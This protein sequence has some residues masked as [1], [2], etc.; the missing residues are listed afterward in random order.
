MLITPKYCGHIVVVALSALAFCVSVS[1]LIGG[2]DGS[3]SDESASEDPE[4]TTTMRA[5]EDDVF[6]GDESTLVTVEVEERDLESL[7]TIGNGDIGGMAVIDYTCGESRELYCKLEDLGGMCGITIVPGFR[8]DRGRELHQL[9]LGIWRMDQDLHR[10]LA[11]RLASGALEARVGAIREEASKSLGPGFSRRMRG[12]IAWVETMLMVGRN[13]LARNDAQLDGAILPQLVIDGDLFAGSP[14]Q[15]TLKRLFGLEALGRRAG[16]FPQDSSGMS[17]GEVVEAIASESQVAKIAEVRTGSGLIRPRNLGDLSL[18]KS[19]RR[20]PSTERRGTSGDV[21]PSGPAL[22]FASPV[23]HLGELALGQVGRGTFR[24]SNKGSAPLEIFGI[25]RSSESTS[26]RGWGGTV[27]PGET[28]SFDVELD[29]A[30]LSGEVAKTVMVESNA[31]RPQI[32]R[33]KATIWSPVTV[34]PRSI[35]FR[36]GSEKNEP[37]EERLAV[38]AAGSE[39]VA[40]EAVHCSNSQF[41]ASLRTLIPGRRY[42]VVVTAPQ[43]EIIAD[44]ATVTLSLDHPR[45]PRISVPVRASGRPARSMA[46]TE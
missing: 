32:L 7:P 46:V 36:H 27:A 35:T 21:R 2:F 16:A 5:G 4:Q 42:E 17:S 25:R 26:V 14:G 23:L 38:S 20:R 33:L 3:V 44:T 45:V 1:L 9:M 24:F 43:P 10:E 40:V 19:T 39:P 11:S 22:I 28:G 29:T 41:Q 34:S 8:D 13:L 12:E 6:G 18:Q 37:V 31:G 30:W 15:P